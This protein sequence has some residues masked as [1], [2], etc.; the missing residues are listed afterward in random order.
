VSQHSL[1]ISVSLGIAD[2]ICFKIIIMYQKSSQQRSNSSLL[3]REQLKRE[4]VILPDVLTSIPID[5]YLRF[6]DSLCDDGKHSFEQHDLSRA[7]VQKQ[8]FVTFVLYK[9]PC[10]PD[11]N[12]KKHTKAAL[13]KSA[14]TSL[15]ELEDIVTSMDA[16]EDGCRNEANKLLLIDEFDGFESADNNNTSSILP[17]LVPQDEDRYVLPYPRDTKPQDISSSFDCLHSSDDQTKE[18][19]KN[20][21]RETIFQHTIGTELATTIASPPFTAWNPLQETGI[22][23][24]RIQSEKDILQFLLQHNAQR[25]FYIPTPHST[26]VNM[27]IG[28]IT[29]HLLRDDFHVQFTPFLRDIPVALQLTESAIETNRSYLSLKYFS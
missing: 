21:M 5:V 14:S 9:L 18:E 7:Y 2:Q 15:Q 23:A 28:D 17:C 6:A 25:T 13:L 22:S 16:I 27:I 20:L 12:M 10:H 1:D 4:Y 19:E 3:F 8:K 26:P 29:I 24:E 11:W